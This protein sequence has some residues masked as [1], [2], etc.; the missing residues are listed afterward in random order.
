MKLAAI[1]QAFCLFL[2]IAAYCG[3]HFS[4]SIAIGYILALQAEQPSTAD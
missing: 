1:G 2:L 4:I 3:A